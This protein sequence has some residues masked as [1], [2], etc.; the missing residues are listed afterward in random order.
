MLRNGLLRTTK[1]M[2]LRK[3][4]CIATSSARKSL[5]MAEAV[6]YFQLMARS[7]GCQFFGQSAFELILP[8]RMSPQASAPCIVR[9][10]A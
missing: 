4:P 9:K 6:A 8:I 10:L 5:S 7:A 2:R 1:R 3:Q